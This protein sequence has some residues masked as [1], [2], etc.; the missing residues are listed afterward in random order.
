MSQL[1]VEVPQR[2]CFQCVVSPLLRTIDTPG[3]V[4]VSK[5]SKYLLGLSTPESLTCCCCCCC[6]SLRYHLLIRWI[7]GCRWSSTMLQKDKSVAVCAAAGEEQLSLLL[8]LSL[9][10][11]LCSRRRETVPHSATGVLPRVEGRLIRCT[12]RSTALLLVV[13]NIGYLRLHCCC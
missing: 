12:I 4:A 7:F 3:A 1:L 8:L 11:L 2:C 9:H 13:N 6:S 10:F 5:R